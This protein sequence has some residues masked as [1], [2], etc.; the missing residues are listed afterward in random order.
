VLGVVRER[1]GSEGRRKGRE[2]EREGRWKGGRSASAL[3]SFPSISSSLL[4]EGRGTELQSE[5]LFLPLNTTYLNLSVSQLSTSR[6]GGKERR[7]ARTDL[8]LRS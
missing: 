2:E 6:A 5:S 8:H 4:L 7:E 1:V 3:C